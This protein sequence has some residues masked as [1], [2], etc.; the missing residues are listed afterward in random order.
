M[1]VISLSFALSAIISVFI[2]YALE[3]KYRIGFL[4]LLSCGFIA[5]Y[6]YYLL[7]YVL[8]YSLINFILGKI[9]PG[10][11]YSKALFNTGIFFNLTQLVVFKYASFVIDPLIGLCNN[12]IKIS[13]ISDVIV[14]IGIS[15]FT[16]QG[17][18]YLVNVKMGWEKPEKNFLHFTLYLIFF[19]KFLSGPIERSNHFL[20]QIKEEKLFNKQHLTEGLRMVLMGFFKKVVIAEPLSVIVQSAY[21]DPGSYGGLNL[22]LVVLTQPLY[23]YFDFSGYTDIAIGIAR[24]FGINLLPNFNKPLFSENVSVLWRRMHMSL[25]F[26][27]NDYVFKQVSFK[28]RKWGKYASVIAVFVTFT[29]FGIWHGAGWNFMVL[30]FLQALAINY[31]FFTKNVRGRIFKKMPVLLRV[32]SG[33]LFTYLFFSIS[34]VFFFS[35]D[36]SAAFNFFGRLNNNGLSFHQCMAMRL[37]ILTFIYVA[38]MLFLEVL[39]IDYMTGYQRLI[40]FWKSHKQVRIAV[41]YIIIFHIVYFFGEETE[42]IYSRF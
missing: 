1:E 13:G 5:T 38:I 40:R 31:E 17:I 20:P 16:L 23:L 24:A 11:K 36:M 12:E 33:R 8:G 4:V 22:W 41:Y 32:W 27:F 9:I 37:L 34:L 35:P 7:I 15:Y 6:N 10:T 29:L 42:F 19:P 3:N 30:G 25:S 2:F 21:S 26:W 18:G 14:P 28:Y 39:E